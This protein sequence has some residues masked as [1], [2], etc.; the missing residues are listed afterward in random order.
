MDNKTDYKKYMKYLHKTNELHKIIMY[1]GNTIDNNYLFYKYCDRLL[2]MNG[3]P[4]ISKFDELA[5][6]K[7]I[8]KTINNVF[9]KGIYGMTETLD[10]PAYNF[11]VMIK[12]SKM[13]ILHPE[14]NSLYEFFVGVCMNRIKYLYPNFP[15]TLSYDINNFSKILALNH[16]TSFDNDSFEKII[17]FFCDSAKSGTSDLTVGETKEVDDTDDQVGSTIITE[18]IENSLEITEFVS[19][20]RK[21]YNVENE[22]E[23]FNIL[24]QIY[25]TL[26]H[27]NSYYVHNNLTIDNVLL[28]KVENDKYVKITYDVVGQDGP[29][30]FTI[31]TKYI[32][33]IINQSSANIDFSYL[34]PN[35]T[36]N[37]FYKQMTNNKMCMINKNKQTEITE[38]PLLKRQRVDLLFINQLM[39]LL[40]SDNYY[41]NILKSAGPLDLI[42]NYYKILEV[43]PRAKNPIETCFVWLTNRYNKTPKFGKQSQSDLL[44]SFVI[45]PR[46]TLSEQFRNGWTFIENEMTSTPSSVTVSPAVSPTLGPSDY[47]MSDD[48]G[49]TPIV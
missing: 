45:K 2:K 4:N 8:K 32:P 5:Y 24:F 17:K 38:M 36:S 25:I 9:M 12:M 34:N 1:G 6:V 20:L 27:M 7:P 23:L 18:Y 46:K 13:S 41:S 49:K 44:G 30:V 35:L 14:N 37:N 21:N 43:L 15:V 26:Y 16:K 19:M 33:V 42:N 48:E 10:K 29:Q 39:T 28:K 3:L 47:Y 22:V 40:L 11:K 31:Y